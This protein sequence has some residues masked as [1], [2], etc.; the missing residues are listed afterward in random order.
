MTITGSIHATKAA[1]S[2]NHGAE[3]PEAAEWLPFVRQLADISA[4]EIKPYY[5]TQC[6]GGVEVRSVA[7]HDR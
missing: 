1:P 6:P 2:G 5:R 7:G 3:N 4:T